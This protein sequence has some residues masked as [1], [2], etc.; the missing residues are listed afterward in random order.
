MEVLPLASLYHSAMR[1][2]VKSYV[3]V[4]DG[5]S[6]VCPCARLTKKI[7][8][9]PNPL[10]VPSRARPLLFRRVILCVAFALREARTFAS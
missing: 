1:E 5:F 3:D 8:L 6:S 7:L 4:Y 10:T 9:A 2:R